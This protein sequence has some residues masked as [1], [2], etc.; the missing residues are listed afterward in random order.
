MNIFKIENDLQAENK[1][2]ELKEVQEDKERLLAICDL[3]ISEY[4]ALKEEHEAKFNGKEE[5]ILNSLKGYAL[6]QN[7]KE[8]KTQGSYQL[9]SAKLVIKKEAEKI[10]KYDEAILIDMFKNTEYVQKKQV[11]SLAW[12]ELKK[13]LTIA[14]DVVVDKNGEIL[15]GVKIERTPE[16]FEVKF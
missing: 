7:L 2:Q 10:V 5:D 1:I 3:K 6:N 4:K 16:R 14:G 8:T 15:D 11:E 12:V 9:P 13:T